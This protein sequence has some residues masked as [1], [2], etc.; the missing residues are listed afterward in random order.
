MINTKNEYWS[1]KSDDNNKNYEEEEAHDNCYGAKEEENEYEHEYSWENFEEEGE[2]EQIPMHKI[3]LPSELTPQPIENVQKEN[4]IE[5]EEIEDCN[6]FGNHTVTEQLINTEDTISLCGISSDLAFAF[7]PL[8][9]KGSVYILSE[10]VQNPL[11]IPDVYCACI[12]GQGILFSCKEGLKMYEDYKLFNVP[13]VLPP[14]REMLT[15]PLNSK[16]FF[17]HC[18]K[19]NNLYIAQKVQNKIRRILVRENVMYFDASRKYLIS[20]NSDN[21]VS[22][23]QRQDTSIISTWNKK[24]DSNIIP[25]ITDDYYL[26]FN[27]TTSQVFVYDMNLQNLQVINNVAQIFKSNTLLILFNDGTMLN[28]H[29]LIRPSNQIICAACNQDIIVAWNSLDEQP[30]IYK[31]KEPENPDDISIA[32]FIDYKNKIIEKTNHFFKN[33]QNLVQN[34]EKQ[35]ETTLSEIRRM[36]SERLKAVDDNIHYISDSLASLQI[37]RK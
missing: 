12:C 11:E 33:V 23:I 16:R 10:N 7:E 30:M 20:S 4:R 8:T 5:I 17:Y 6:P 19:D 3:T 27:Q 35:Q 31:V 26:E 18:S 22:C 25:Y 21:Y 15:D 9:G 13:S 14:A 29:T 34:Q 32:E 2:S 28:N 1:E 36:Y 24:I 37:K